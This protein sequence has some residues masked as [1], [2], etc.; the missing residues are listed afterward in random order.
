MDTEG[1][2]LYNT[3]DHTKTADDKKRRKFLGKN[4]KSLTRVRQSREV[5]PIHEIGKVKAEQ[6]DLE[7]GEKSNR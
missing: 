3:F 6:V 4:D 2:Q 1:S 7:V 5:T